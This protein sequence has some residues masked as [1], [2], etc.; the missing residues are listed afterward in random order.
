MGSQRER[1]EVPAPSTEG[2]LVAAQ[3]PKREALLTAALALTCLALPAAP[4]EA[5]LIETGAC[6]DAALSQP[7]APWNDDRHYKLAPGGDVEGPSTAG[8]SRAARRSS[9]AASRSPRPA[10]PAAVHSRSRP[11]GRSPRAA[12][13]VNFDYPSFRFFAKSSGG[14]L[15]LAARAEGRPRLPRRACWASSRCRSGR[16][17]RATAGSRR[18]SMFSLSAVGA[19]SPAA[20]RRSPSGSPRWPARGPS[21]TCSSTPSGAA[22]ASSCQGVVVPGTTGTTTTPT[23]GASPWAT[24]RRTT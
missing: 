4:A 9:P 3:K 13:C 11:V 14:L 5:D 6:D 19:A 8:P 18:S 24:E 15:G 12:T 21:T 22:S 23:R 16:S 17:C 10:R 2:E 7:F 1:T 20:R